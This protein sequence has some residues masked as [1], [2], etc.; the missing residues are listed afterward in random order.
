MDLRRPPMGSDN[1]PFIAPNMFPLG[2]LTQF[3]G[4]ADDIENGVAAAGD[5]LV[6][7]S[8]V[9]EE[10]TLDVQFLSKFY[11][12]GG[13]AS[14]KGCVAGDWVNFSLHAPAT[15]GSSNPGAGV[16]DKFAL[17]AG[18]NMY[19]P[20]ATQ[21]GG[22]DLDLTEKLNE[23]VAFTKATP[24]PAPGQDG[25]FDYEPD[26]NV[27]TLNVTQTGRYNLFDFDVPMH[28]FVQ[29]VPMIGDSL[30]LFTVPAVKPYLCLPHWHVTITISN[31][32]EKNV[33]F[34]AMLYRGI[35]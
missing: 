30:E 21:Q 13:A 11:L 28:T 1:R 8:S 34:G 9:V 19:I 27:L 31:S 7:E 2:H 22:W 3:T 25:F 20:N 5:L 10:K 6:M 23:N 4:V 18:M 35:T 26:T 33:E 16:Y 32:T 15:V 29:K 14:W 24:V 17:G 12:A